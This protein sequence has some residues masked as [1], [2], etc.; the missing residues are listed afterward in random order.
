[1]RIL[2]MTDTK[3]IEDEESKVDNE[4]KEKENNET[5]LC[6]DDDGGSSEDTKE[7][8]VTIEMVD[9]VSTPSALT[10]VELTDDLRMMVEEGMI[11]HEQALAM[12]VSH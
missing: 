5:S 3:T 2:K 6:D 4:D 12:L 8:H 11:T 9:I 1:M 10:P 7:N